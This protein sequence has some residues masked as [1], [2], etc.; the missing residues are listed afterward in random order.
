MEV[1]EIVFNMFILSWNSE[2]YTGRLVVGP[3]EDSLTI[4]LR[5]EV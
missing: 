1:G 5:L 2:F 4:F 3:V